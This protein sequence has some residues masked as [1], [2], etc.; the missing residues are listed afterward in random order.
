MKNA[1]ILH[2][3]PS[4]LEY[5]EMDF[6]SPSNAHWIPW[7]QQKFLRAGVQ[8]QT[9]EMPHPYAPEYAAWENAF[10]PFT[11]C[12]DSIFVGHSA[13]CG[14]ILKWLSIHPEATI[15]KWSLLRPGLTLIAMPGIFLSVILILIWKGALEKSM[16]FFQRMILKV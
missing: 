16:F 10:R 13:G 11:P 1:I 8:C 7:L 6:P 2:G 14:F 9:P 5:Y 4:L 15:E 12:P 3:K